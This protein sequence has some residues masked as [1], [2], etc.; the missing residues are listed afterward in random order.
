MEQRL[1]VS[2]K[3]T[4]KKN[5]VNFKFLYGNSATWNKPVPLV[6]TRLPS[7]QVVDEA[8]WFWHHTDCKSEVDESRPNTTVATNSEK[9]PKSTTQDVHNPDVFRNFH[10]SKNSLR[11]KPIEGIVPVTPTWSHDDNQRLWHEK[12]SFEHTYDSRRPENYPAR[13]KR[14]GAFVWERAKPE[15]EKMFARSREECWLDSE[16]NLAADQSICLENFT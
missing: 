14:Q 13:G 6:F 16:K 12:M 8:Q 4:G 3:R 11:R 2:D 5:A 7:G 15:T 9:T 10:N 1:N